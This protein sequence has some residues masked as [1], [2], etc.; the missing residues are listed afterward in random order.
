MPPLDHGGN[1]LAVDRRRTPVNLELP[2]DGF[3]AAGIIGL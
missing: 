3:D 2:I 1:A